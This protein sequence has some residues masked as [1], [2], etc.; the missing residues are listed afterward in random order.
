MPAFRFSRCT[1]AI[2]NRGCN[3]ALR[4]LERAGHFILSPSVM[5]KTLKSP[6]RLKLA[7]PDPI[8]V[9]GV[10]GAVKGLRMIK[11]DDVDQ[12]RLWNEMMIRCRRRR[13]IGRNQP[14]HYWLLK[15]RLTVAL[16][17]STTKAIDYSLR[18]WAALSRYATDGRLPID[19][20]PVENV[21]R[22][23]AIGKKNG[24]F[25]GS[26]RAGQRV[27]AIQSLLATAKLNGFDPAA[28]LRETLEKLPLASIPR[29]IR[30]CRCART[31]YSKLHR[32]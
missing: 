9:P 27:A 32:K 25:V 11:V 21:I 23:I 14:T 29:S 19:N 28:W 22:P 17:G 16:G 3:K 8:D 30:C 7:V 24:L 10:V 4:A 26:E 5:P 18:R 31:R 2:P 6:R 1:R 15:N 20:N 13:E 12:M